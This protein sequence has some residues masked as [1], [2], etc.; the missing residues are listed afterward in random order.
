M[1]N[2]FIIF[3]LPNDEQFYFLSNQEFGSHK[4]EFL[5]FDN[6]KK[7]MFKNNVLKK[8]D[9]EDFCF[10]NL[11]FRFYSA[12]FI[13]NIKKYCT[14]VDY[15]IDQ[16]RNQ[17]FQKIVVSRIQKFNYS[18]IDLNCSIKNLRI[19]FPTAFVYFFVKNDIIWMGATPEFLGK[20]SGNLFET[21]SLAGTIFRE[22]TFSLKEINEQKIVTNFIKNI[23]KK[24]AYSIIE[25]NSNLEYVYGNLK[26]LITYFRLLINP[27]NYEKLINQLYPT[28]AICG[29]PQMKT[30]N[31]IKQ[32]EPHNR[33]FY[34]GKIIINLFVSKMVF[35]NLRCLQVFRNFFEVF[36]GSG[37]TLDS[38]SA[39]EWNETENKIK[40]I[41]NNLI[42]F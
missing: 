28:P 21:I 35:I 11:K 16:I 13:L 40:S 17:F 32:I 24:Y 18:K 34:A 27:L 9:L 39:Y 8:I 6:S 3:S 41:V 31:F 38:V 7:I 26:H 30:F 5:S 29:L 37:I 15:C 22:S 20:I 19:K 33:E 36:V 2:D 12:S 14:I 10:N 4:I 25:M 23:L 1:N 42:Y